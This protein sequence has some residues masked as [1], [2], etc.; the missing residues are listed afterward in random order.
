MFAM[1]RLLDMIA[2]QDYKDRLNIFIGCHWL[3]ISL[4][5]IPG[6]VSRYERVFSVD[7]E[8]AQKLKAL[9]DGLDSVEWVRIL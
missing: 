4:S 9:N 8:V 5:V 3:V 7:P 6:D 1:S 2:A